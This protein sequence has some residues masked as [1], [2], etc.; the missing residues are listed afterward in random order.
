MPSAVCVVVRSKLENSANFGSQALAILVVCVFR[1]PP[2]D[3]G[4][5]CLSVERGVHTSEHVFLP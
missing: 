5:L 4:I 3:K 2:G 1:V